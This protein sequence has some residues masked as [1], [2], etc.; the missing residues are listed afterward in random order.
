MRHHTMSLLR[1]P[2]LVA[3]VALMASVPGRVQAQAAGKVFHACRIPGV[4]AIYMIKE[5]GLPDNLSVGGACGIQLDG[6]RG[7]PSRSARCS[8]RQRGYRRSG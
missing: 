4:G 8:G 3:T 5:S 7:R 1:L 6:G 2:V